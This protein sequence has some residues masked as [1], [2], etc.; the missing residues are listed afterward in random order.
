[1]PMSVDG[2]LCFL[3]AMV[4]TTD[5]KQPGLKENWATS[6]SGGS[7]LAEARWTVV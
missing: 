2:T 4:W 7:A 1:M 3:A 6:M 5:W